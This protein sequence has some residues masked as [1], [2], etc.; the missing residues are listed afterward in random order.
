MFIHMHPNAYLHTL[1]LTFIYIPHT[2]TTAT[3][4]TQY[5]IH[6]HHKEKSGAEEMV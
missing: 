5:A 1:K 2:Q 6:I 3:Q 4:H